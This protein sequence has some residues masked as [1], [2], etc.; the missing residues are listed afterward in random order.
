MYREM[1]IGEVYSLAAGS[2]SVESGRSMICTLFRKM[3]LE[4]RNHRRGDA[5][6]RRYREP[7]TPR[8]CG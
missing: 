2:A 8:E 3:V 6:L 1:V 4:G 7:C 5:Y